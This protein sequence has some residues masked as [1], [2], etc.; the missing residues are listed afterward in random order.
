MPVVGGEGRHQLVSWE[1][2]AAHPSSLDTF[3]PTAQGLLG[4]A[5]MLMGMCLYSFD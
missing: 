4:M 2:S 5:E 3:F 1:G